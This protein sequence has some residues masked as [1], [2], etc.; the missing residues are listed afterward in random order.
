MISITF[1]KNA[2]VAI[3]ANGCCLQTHLDS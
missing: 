2:T 1:D 3:E